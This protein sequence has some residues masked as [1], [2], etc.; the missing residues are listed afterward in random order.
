MSD[1]TIYLIR[2]GE[3]D[4]NKKG[5]VQGSGIDSVL[6]E[7][8]NL[9]AQAFFDKYK[10]MAFEKVYTSALQ[11]THQSV[12]GFLKKGLNHEVLPGLNEI[13][14]GV[15]E[16]KIPNNT[17]KAFYGSIIKRWANGE[18]HVAIEGGESPEEVVARQKVAIDKI[19]ENKSEKLILVAM[20]G[21]AL[22]IILSQISN[23]PLREMDNFKHSNLCLYKI[24]YAYQSNKFTILSQNDITH[25]SG[26]AI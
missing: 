6:N 26:L 11:R 8:G 3:T 21:R 23:T 16:G 2:H 25:L 18:T 1:K 5:I 10:S 14:W 7:K 17:E 12:I 22:R 20:H 19:L 24:S 9:Q 15:K 4:Y 13:S